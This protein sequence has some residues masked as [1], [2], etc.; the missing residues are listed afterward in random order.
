[1]P[2]REIP[3]LFE[4]VPPSLFGPL[5][6][7]L[8]PLYWSLLARFYQHEFEREP[9]H[10]VRPVAI[11]EAEGILASSPLWNERR[12]ELLGDDD[13]G[14]DGLEQ[15][16]DE[17]A[18]RMMSARRLVQ[19]LERAG[20][21]RFEYRSGLGDVL[22]FYPYAARLLETLVRVA[23]DEQPVF[24]G[25]AHTIAALLR[26]EAF[27]AQ[28]GAALQ[29]AVRHTLELVRELKILNRNIAAHTQRL[30]DEAERAADVLEQGL[31]HYETA[32][33]ASYHRLKTTHNLF[34]WRGDVLTRLEAIANDTLSLGA[35]ARWSAEQSSTDLE[36]AQRA[37]Q[38]QLALVRMQFETLPTI[39]DDIDR[40]NAR[41]SGTALRKLMYLLR[42]DKR[43]EGQLQYLVDA[44]TGE[45]A[46]ELELDVYRCELLAK[47]FLHT[48]GKKRPKLERQPLRDDSALDKR[49]VR[50]A[51]SQHLK[52]RFSR[53]E[54]E[55]RV[56]ALLA[57]RTSA[58]L[59]ELGLSDDEDYVSTI[60]A[61][62]YG[63]DQGS[64]YTFHVLPGSER[65]GSFGVPRG[66]L[67]RKGKK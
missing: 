62:A 42:Q 47:D 31:E 55:A 2:F 35:A 25:Y 59:A 29:E 32:V 28:P 34:K 50:D 44:L 43:T 5:S 63:L 65:A 67:R 33:H 14:Q 51:V 46:P 20:W 40:R 48:P 27:A 15:A 45:D 17:A 64:A 39:T 6:G 11:D 16:L 21:Y 30:L 66:E 49:A 57:G 36:S 23:R 58:R 1:M 56:L 19:R 7:P 3:P 12:A 38:E 22:S 8:A 13:A 18:L 52:A 60:Y 24:Q 61:A 4:R 26:A 54:L 53:K 10:L 41:F 37:V 9:F